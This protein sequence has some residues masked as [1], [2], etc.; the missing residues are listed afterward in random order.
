LWNPFSPGNGG[1]NPYISPAQSAFTWSFGCIKSD[2]ENVSKNTL[3]LPWGSTDKTYAWAGAF[4]T[5][6]STDLNTG[7]YTVQG[8]QQFQGNDYNVIAGFRQLTNPT[9]YPPVNPNA[10]TAIS[11]F[12]GVPSQ[13]YP[14]AKSIN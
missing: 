12:Q 4:D 6:W 10:N 1:V 3:G 8:T 11:V 5:Y 2:A 14:L 9:A 13:Y 7:V